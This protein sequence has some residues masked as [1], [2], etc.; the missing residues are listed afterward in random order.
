MQGT[1]GLLAGIA[2]ASLVAVA[3]VAA[4]S[5]TAAEGHGKRACPTRDFWIGAGWGADRGKRAH[6]GIDLGGKRGTEIY[7]VEDGV[8]DRT[9][10]QDN[11]ALQ[12]V[13]RGVSGAKFY[14]G[15]MDEV[16]VKGR[17]RVES[18]QVI[19]LMGD[20]GSPGSVHLHFEF[21]RSGGESDPID[22]ARLIERICAS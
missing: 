18:G 14:Y 11:G 20:S 5:A 8:I 13:M 15:H 6:H 19:G 16:L 3:L 2:A 22:P 12:I 9:K 1:R 17:Q 4:P 10:L 21:W 7:A